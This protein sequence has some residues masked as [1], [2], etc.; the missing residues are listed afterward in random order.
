MRRRENESPAGGRIRWRPGALV[1]R[2][3]VGR[4]IIIVALAGKRDRGMA[5]ATAPDIESARV[6]IRLVPHPDGYIRDV[7]A[8]RRSI[9]PDAFPGRVP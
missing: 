3:P 9:W 5:S 6:G 1:F 4:G 2:S 7:S 8:V